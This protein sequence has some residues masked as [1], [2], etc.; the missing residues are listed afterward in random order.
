MQMLDAV[1]AS[2]AGRIISLDE[3]L[4]GIATCLH[5]I[6]DLTRNVIANPKTEQRFSPHLICSTVYVVL[7]TPDHDQDRIMV[8]SILMADNNR[9]R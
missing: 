8:D 5:I 6:Y 1:F 7:F 9:Q 4:T 3:H 2:D